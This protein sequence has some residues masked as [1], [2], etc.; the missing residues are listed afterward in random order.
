MDI[1]GNLADRFDRVKGLPAGAVAER[2]ERR[3]EPER[4]QF[5]DVA[6]Q[7]F[8]VDEAD[9]RVGRAAAA[10]AQVGASIAAVWFSAMPSTT[11]VT[12]LARTRPCYNAVPRSA[13]FVICSGAPVAV[14]P[15]RPDQHRRR[16]VGCV[17]PVGLACRR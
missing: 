3:L 11:I 13:I 12:V 7:R 17:H 1:E 8:R 16:R 4:I 5:D 14:P 15:L 9:P 10:P 6:A 2:M